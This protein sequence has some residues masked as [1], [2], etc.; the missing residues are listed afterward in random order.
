MSRGHKNEGLSRKKLLALLNDIDCTLSGDND[1]GTPP[2]E[3]AERIFDCDRHRESTGRLRTRN[4]ARRTSPSANRHCASRSRP[5]YDE[6]RIRFCTPRLRRC[7]LC[8]VERDTIKFDK[9]EVIDYIPAE[10]IV[11]VDLREIVELPSTKARSC[12][13]R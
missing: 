12:G 7:P 1:N 10:V 5:T 4:T 9:T 2:N 6:S 11:R 13:P 8:A 3:V